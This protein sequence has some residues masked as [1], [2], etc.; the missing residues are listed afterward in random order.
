MNIN[1]KLM[2][3]GACGVGLSV[4]QPIPGAHRQ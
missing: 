3:A 4:D 1:F 2:Q